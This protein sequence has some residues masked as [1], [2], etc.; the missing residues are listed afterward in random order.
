MPAW[1]CCTLQTLTGSLG[2]IATA[3][4]PLE[5]SASLFMEAMVQTPVGQGPSCLIPEQLTGVQ[6]TVQG[7][8]L[9]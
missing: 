4:I 9:L 5:E 2:S 6:G 3:C 8:T 1:L 7:K